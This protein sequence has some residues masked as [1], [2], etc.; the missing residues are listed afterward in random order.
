MKTTLLVLLLLSVLVSCS[1]TKKETLTEEKEHEDIQKEYTVIDSSSDKRPGWIENASLWAKMHGKDLVVN[2]YFSYETDPFQKKSMACSKAKASAYSD[3]ARQIATF[4]SKTMASSEEG[5]AAIDES[6]PKTES[7]RSFMED[8]LAEKIQALIHGAKVEVTYW[9]KRKYE[10]A[11]GAKKDYNA[12]TC[13]AF[14]SMENARLKEAIDKAANFTAASTDDPETKAN[15][16]K[17]LEEVSNDF[18]KAKKG[19]I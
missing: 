10:K 17:A 1:S 5:T 7:I 3:I 15:V 14:V 12:Y 16:K 19:E 11:L 8:T 2:S 6:N 13:A 9:E 4:I 18:I